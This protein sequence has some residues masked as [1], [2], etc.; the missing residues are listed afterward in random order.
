VSHLYL[1]P[2][3][4]SS[5]SPRAQIL[6]PERSGSTHVWRKSSTHVRRGGSARTCDSSRS[7][8][9]KVARCGRVAPAGGAA[10]AG[11]AGCLNRAPGRAYRGP[12]CMSSSGPRKFDKPGPLTKSK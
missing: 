8:Q 3:F 6:C 7:R 1:R 9:I 4:F 5:A 10:S 11:L 12:G 2:A